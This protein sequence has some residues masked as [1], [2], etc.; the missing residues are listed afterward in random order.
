LAEFAPDHENDFEL[1]QEVA[2]NL[3]GPHDTDYSFPMRQCI[4]DPSKKLQTGGWL[5]DLDATQA[6]ARFES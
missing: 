3:Q 2:H 6:E 5:V 4:E 1:C